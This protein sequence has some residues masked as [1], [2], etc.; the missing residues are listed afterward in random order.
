MS[1]LRRAVEAIPA[2]ERKA[3]LAEVTALCAR[4]GIT[5]PLYLLAV[6][7]FESRFSPSIVNPS[8][9]ATGLIQFIPSTARKLGTTTAALKG[10]SRLQ[11]LKY[12]EAY[13][14]DIRRWTKVKKFTSYL[15]LYISTFHPAALGKADSYVVGR[16]GSNAYDWNKAIDT[17]WGNADGVLTL[18]DFR[19]YATTKFLKAIG[20]DTGNLA[21]KATDTKPTQAGIFSGAAGWLIAGTLV[22]V[23]ISAMAKKNTIHTTKVSE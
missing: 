9:G 3:F 1:E 10:M 14:A 13:Y 2:S 19:A 23:A 21:P 7:Y 11:Q 18:G 4:Q 22:T 20:K 12:V 5:N 17:R 8:G 6:M 16:K 15:D